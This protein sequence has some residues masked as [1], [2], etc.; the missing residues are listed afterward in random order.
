MGGVDV[1]DQQLS[2]YSL[3]QSRSPKWWKKVFW[4]LLDI[5]LINSLIIF[6]AN[7]P[8]SSTDTQLKYRTEL[9]RQLVQPLLY[10]KASPQFPPSLQ[11]HRGCRPIAVSKCLTGKHFPYKFTR[12]GRFVVCY[13]QKNPRGNQRT[14]KH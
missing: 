12:R 4:R 13:K 8:E 3:T 6:R 9:C 1:M 7:N 2:Y 14:Q 11:V 5:T 10:L